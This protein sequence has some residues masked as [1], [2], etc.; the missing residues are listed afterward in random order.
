MSAPRARR[1]VLAI[2]QEDDQPAVPVG[3][4]QVAMAERL[5]L[6]GHRRQVRSLLDLQRQLAGGCE[7][8]RGANGHESRDVRERRRRVLGR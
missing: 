6:V 7:V 4:G 5:Q 8:R 3:R 2:G 1:P